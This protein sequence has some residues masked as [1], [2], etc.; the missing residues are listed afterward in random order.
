MDLKAFTAHVWPDWG[1][2]DWSK[3]LILF[4]MF[5][6]FLAMGLNSEYE[7]ILKLFIPLTA[8]TVELLSWGLIGGSSTEEFLSTATST[9]GT[10]ELG[11]AP[12]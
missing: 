7:D 1:V 2:S 10:G 4:K 6:D 11:F 8:S 3:S 5:G 9:G 12:I